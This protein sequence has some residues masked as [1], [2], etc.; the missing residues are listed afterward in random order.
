VSKI[1]FY[2]TH[3]KI[4]VEIS[5]RQVYMESMMLNWSM[6]ILLKSKLYDIQIH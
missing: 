2:T 3:F 1:T 4:F 5:S 6:Q